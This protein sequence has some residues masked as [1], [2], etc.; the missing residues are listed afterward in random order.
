MADEVMNGTA[1]PAYLE[2]KVAEPWSIESEADHL[3]DDLFSDV[4]GILDGGSQLPTKPA[5]G[6]YVSLRSVVPTE[7]TMSSTSVPAPAER[8]VTSQSSRKVSA[9]PSVRPSAKMILA[10]NLDKV[11]FAI[12]GLSLVG[13]VVWLATQGKLNLQ[14][15]QP[16]VTST[17]ESGSSLAEL[18]PEEAAF[19]QY[20]LRSLQAIERRPPSLTAA[21]PQT[22]LQA[23]LTA[24]DNT[25][26]APQSPQ[27]IERV[28]IPVYPPNPNSAD[29]SGARSQDNQ[30][31]TP[32]NLSE[33]PASNS[34]PPAPLPQ[35]NRTAQS[36]VPRFPAATIP[37]PPLARQQQVLPPLPSLDEA[38]GVAP[39][40]PLPSNTNK[41]V[42]ILDYGDRSTALFMV[43]ETTQRISVGEPIGDSGWTLVSTENRQATVRR[44]GEVRSI[45][46]GQTF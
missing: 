4:D 18:P 46:V 9:A 28:Y 7:L 14:R 22:P 39:S 30:P 38:P 36:P 23:N 21:T 43:G 24:P 19:G 27:V 29:G 11:F 41:L 32:P 12:A 34:T 15:V 5:Q 3:M 10:Q 2:P 6:N 45:Y 17:V 26:A 35:N 13:V 31:V 37:A 20:M 1:S 16:A 25:A 33:N 42:G 40:N 44:N 8:A